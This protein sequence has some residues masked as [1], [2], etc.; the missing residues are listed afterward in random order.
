MIV[1]ELLA[2]AVECK[3]CGKEHKPRSRGPHWAPTW[4]APDGHS[5]NP[6]LSVSALA[7]LRALVS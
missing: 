2:R 7:E 6:R 4:A 5:Y 3:T 1:K